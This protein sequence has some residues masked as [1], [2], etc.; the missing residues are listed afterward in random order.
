[1]SFDLSQTVKV[2]N[3]AADVDFFYGTYASPAAACAAVPASIRQIGKTVG[4]VVNDGGIDSVVEYWWRQGTTDADL[5][6]KLKTVTDAISALDSRVSALPTPMQFKGSLGVNGTI[7]DLPAAAAANNGFVYKVITAGTYA[8]LAAKVGDVLISNGENWVLVPSGDEPSGTVTSVAAGAGLDGGTITESGTISLSDSGATAGSY[9]NSADQTPA[10]GATFNV[11]YITVDRYGRITS[12]SNKTVK[13]PASDNTDTGATSVEVTGSGN[14]VTT[15]SYSASTRKLTL[16]KGTTFL[17]SHQDISGKAPN[18]HA[19]SATTYGV[20]TSSNYGHVKLGAANQN[21]ATAANGVAAPN[22][23]T[24]S[25][26]L[27]SHQTVTTSNSTVTISYA[28]GTKTASVP[29]RYVGSSRVAGT[30]FVNIDSYSISAVSLPN[31]IAGDALIFK[32]YSNTVQAAFY[33]GSSW[34]IQQIS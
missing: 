10:Y 13:I 22:G 30:Y 27:T 26:Y 5:E 6:P 32:R 15:A 25:Q 3:P 29:L 20:A 21:G 4:I 23:H 16:T 2:A 18:N 7:S 17:T 14:A 34:T 11:P 8:G 28:G 1:M 24:H 19:S 33:D 12:I 9:G 31:A